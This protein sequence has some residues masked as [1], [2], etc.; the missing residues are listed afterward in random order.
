L[1]GEAT[2]VEPVEHELLEL[3]EEVSRDPGNLSRVRGPERMTIPGSNKS[4]SAVPPF[5]V[6]GVDLSPT[7]V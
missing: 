3:L 4:C 5:R 2:I 7:S 1:C 6:D